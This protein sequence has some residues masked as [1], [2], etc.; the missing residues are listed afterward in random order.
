MKKGKLE[1]EKVKRI[2]SKVLGNYYTS[3]K[4]LYRSIAQRLSKLPDTPSGW[5][6][7]DWALVKTLERILSEE[8][9]KCAWIDQDI[10]D[11]NERS[12]GYWLISCASNR[13][14]AEKLVKKIMDWFER[15]TSFRVSY[16]IEEVEAEDHS[17]KEFDIY[18]EIREM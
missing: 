6:D 3:F 17:G 15:N 1:K 10:I 11:S 2:F 12:I 7:Y 16:E 9:S 4:S 5:W 18:L 14:E 8:K 13:D